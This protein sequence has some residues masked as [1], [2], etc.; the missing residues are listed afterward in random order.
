M[1]DIAELLHQSAQGITFR[2]DA[3]E[4]S[5]VHQETMALFDYWG[6]GSSRPLRAVSCDPQ[7]PVLLCGGSLPLVSAVH[8]A[9]SQ[10]L[11][12]RLT[13]DMVWLTLA[14][15]FAHHLVN[16]SEALRSLMVD[17]DRQRRLRVETWKDPMAPNFW[18]DVIEQ[19]AALIDTHSHPD[20]ANLIICDFST[21]T[22]VVRTASQILL[23]HAMREYFRYELRCICGI[24]QITLEGTVED[25]QD[26]LARVHTMSAYYLEWWTDRLIPICE[27][28]IAAAKGIPRQTFWRQLYKPR[29]LYGGEIITGWLAD[30]FPYLEHPETLAPIVRNPVLAKPREQLTID[31]G[32]LS[33]QIPEGLATV[34]IHVQT[35]T[36][37]LLKMELLG[38]FLGVEQEPD[39]GIITSKLGWGVRDRSVPGA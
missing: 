3:V 5:R 11:P 17:H 21:T 9:F 18:P 30:L 24:P 31:D 14:Q 34:P 22:P 13:P 28:F 26:I 15:G 38:G 32:L 12:L 4:L 20:I 16:H 29:E 6:G 27:E 23:M 19:W 10:H 39:S 36:G 8:L 37:Q 1:G 33:S 7:T 25:W 35:S 2:V